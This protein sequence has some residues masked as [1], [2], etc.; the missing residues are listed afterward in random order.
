MKAEIITIGDEILLGQTVD[1]NS[2]WIAHRLAAHQ[3]YVEQIT[4][5]TDTQDHII[6]AL[7][8]AGKRSE[9]I[10]CTGG[11]GPTRDDITKEAAARYFKSTLVFNSEVME[12]VEA[13]F[14]RISKPMPAINQGQAHV[15]SNAEVLTN[16]WGTAPGMWVEHQQKIYVF[17]PGV[18]Y[19]MRNLID[20]RVLP[21]LRHQPIVDSVAMRYLLV[22]GVG[23]SFLAEQIAEIE[24]AMPDYVHL[25]Y[26]P[27]IGIIKLRI[28]ARGGHVE[29]LEKEVDTWRDRISLAIG[30]AVVCAEDVDFAAVIIRAFSSLGLTFGTAES[31]T[32]GQI[33]AR[34]TAVSG[35]S[36][37]FRGSV[38]AYDNQIKNQL[39]GVR[40]ATLERYGAVSEEVVMEMAI[41]AKEK[42]KTNYAIATSGIAGPT[43]GTLQKPV[44]TVWIAVAGEQE[45]LRRKFLFTD[46]RAVNIERTVAQSL[47]MLWEL[48]Q[49]EKEE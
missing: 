46:G 26:L 28:T 14:S 2:S 42:L 4:S 49:K 39:L 44:G 38:V 30:P 23:E 29:Q 45:V 24:D 19:E 11:L 35:S 37:M 7:H 13:I 1:T 34:I 48:F 18:P 3:I 47:L 27:Q 12:H 16:D 22:V 10:I 36:S 32:G 21:K 33:A 6:Y 31:C 8:E 17:L 25:A 9:L 20:N 5:I 43:G 15:L 40:S 41:G